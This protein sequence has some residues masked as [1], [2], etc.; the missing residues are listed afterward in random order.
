MNSN[1]LKVCAAAAVLMLFAAGCS[2]GQSAQTSDQAGAGGPGGNYAMR[3]NASS[4]RR[5]GFRMNMPAGAKPIFG[6]ITAVN[7]SVLTLSP[8]GRNP[9]STSTAAIAATTLQ[10]TVDGSTQYQGGVASDLKAGVR[11][12]G[13]GTTT[14]DGTIEAQSLRIVTMGGGGPG[15]PGGGRGG[16][17]GGDRGPGGYGD[18]QGGGQ[19]PAGDQGGR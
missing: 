11:V 4:T 16:Y 19:P 3:G 2:S 5:G 14:A 1:I 18:G 9:N 10:V 17:G 12:M 6:S 8:A 13:Y 7:G 15:G